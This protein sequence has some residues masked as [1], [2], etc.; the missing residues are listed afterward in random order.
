VRK[1]IV[2]GGVI[3]LA[4]VLGA[5][6][7]LHNEIP[8][9]YP[10]N[11]QH[12]ESVPE[13]EAT[14][15]RVPEGHLTDITPEL[16]RKAYGATITNPRTQ[17]ALLEELM[18]SLME[19]YPDDWQQRLAALVKEAFPDQAQEILKRLA[20]L[21]RYNK[22]LSQENPN[23]FRMSRRER[24]QVLQDK[25]REVF[26]SDA[27]VIWAGD[28]AKNKLDD[29]LDQINR[30]DQASIYEKL[31]LYSKSLHEIYNDKAG[32]SL[33]MGSFELISEFLE[34]GSVQRDLEAMRPEE[35][36]QGLRRIRASLGL[37]DDALSRLEA[38][39][40]V[41][42]GRWKAGAEYMRERTELVKTFTG[43][44]REQKIIAL[45]ERYFGSQS[46][47]IAKE[48][49]AGFFRFTRKRIY[50]MN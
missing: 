40:A 15:K 21:Q 8:R 2:I 37:D 3:V 32:S 38:L 12:L 39:D 16:I 25:R 7:S 11:L 26:G 44:A 28:L 10:K 29:V 19:Q 45:R 20:D 30:D 43:T 48:E 6:F 34:V 49:E 17:I 47:S 33:G 46:E 24:S 18:G 42:D 9:D 50:G 1:W 22:W 23:L 27:E 31:D 41:R 5:F 4:G 36:T 13:V 35:R 14:Q